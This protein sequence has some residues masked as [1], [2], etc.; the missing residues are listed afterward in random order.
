MA[1]IGK[2][3]RTVV[4]EPLPRPRREPREAPAKEP[5]VPAAPKPK[6]RE[7]VPA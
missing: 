7:R 2:P 4:V 6:R 5:A 3:K 1:P